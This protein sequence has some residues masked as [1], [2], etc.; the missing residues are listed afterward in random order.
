[1]TG[2][3]NRLAVVLFGPPG[4]GK[5]TQAKLLEGRLGIPHVSTGDILREHV[6]AGDSLGLEV[7]SVM[8]AGGLVPDELVS[9]LV[10]ER[11]SRPDAGNGFLLDGYPRTVRQAETLNGMLECRGADPVVVHLRVDYNRIIGRL[12]ARRQCLQCGALY[13]LV[14]N[15]PKAAGRCD[16]DDSSLVLRDDD[17]EPVI[18]Q[19]LRAYDEQTRPV[20][21]YYRQ[22]PGKF[23]EVD[24]GDGAPEAIAGEICRLVGQE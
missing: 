16:R 23:F 4:S 8:Q 5:G 11:I 20:L 14:S 1:M 21:D 9:R 13:N 24:G 15:P 10:E 12:S 22:R 18:R 17:S 19:R 3:E 7:R 6:A 2:K